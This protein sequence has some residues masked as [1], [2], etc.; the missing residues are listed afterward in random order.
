MKRKWSCLPIL[1]LYKLI[2][3]LSKKINYQGVIDAVNE[4][5]YKGFI[6]GIFLCLKGFTIL[7]CRSPPF[8]QFE[9]NSD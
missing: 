8:N 3:D 2:A 5:Y 9:K 4:T 1:I 7:R 6:H